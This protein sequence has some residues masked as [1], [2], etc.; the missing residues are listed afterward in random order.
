MLLGVALVWTMVHKG[1]ISIIVCVFFK[2]VHIHFAGHI[3]M[4][5][6][7]LSTPKVAIYVGATLFFV[8]ADID[9]GA[10]PP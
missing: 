1:V 8:T 3:I 9:V 4:W 2:I 5:L 7:T 10:Y 6:Y